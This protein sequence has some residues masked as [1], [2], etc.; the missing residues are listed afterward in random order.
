MVLSYREGLKIEDGCKGS[1]DISISA[2]TLQFILKNEY[3]ANTTHVNGKFERISDKGVAVFSRHFSPQEY[4]K[5]GYG[6][7]NP[8]TTFW[9]V[10]CKLFHKLRKKAWG[11]NATAD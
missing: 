2:S 8:F 5:I 9:I 6:L 1:C 4:M 10:G 11:V 3:G 7:N